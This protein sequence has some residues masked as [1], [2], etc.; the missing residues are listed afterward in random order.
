MSFPKQSKDQTPFEKAIYTFAQETE[1]PFSLNQLLSHLKHSLRYMPDQ[2]PAL[3]QRALEK[4]PSVFF[5][6]DQSHYVPRDY[7]FDGKSFLIK[8]TPLEIERGCLILGHRLLPFAPADGHLGQPSLRP[9]DRKRPLKTVEQ[10]F[11]MK[12][13]GIF[14][15]MCGIHKLI[16]DT[17]PLE[18]LSTKETLMADSDAGSDRVALTVFDLRAFFKRY[19]PSKDCGLKV[20]LHSYNEQTY[21]FEMVHQIG[22]KQDEFLIR[23]WTE[24][25]EKSITRLNSELGP[26]Y[27]VE[28]QLG[29]ALFRN[30]HLLERTPPIHIGGALALFKDLALQNLNNMPIFWSRQ[31]DVEHIFLDLADAQSPEPLG[32]LESIPDI[33]QDLGIQVSMELVNAYVLNG[34]Y[35]GQK[36]YEPIFDH[37]CEV[38]G[39]FEFYNAEQE[40]VFLQQLKEVF[41]NLAANYKREND[42]NL[43]MLRQRALGLFDHFWTI[44]R[45]EIP[46][47]TL[48]QADI[49]PLSTM[50]MLMGEL[51][52][53]MNLEHNDSEFD[54]NVLMF[55]DQNLSQLE[56]MF[57]TMVDDYIGATNNASDAAPPKPVAPTDQASGPPIPQPKP[58]AK[59]KTKPTQVSHFTVY[60]GEKG[61]S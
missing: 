39:K 23:R 30:P 51:T 12:E 52:G 4:D 36:S 55:L 48:E 13:L 50:G 53:L 6:S 10:E 8:L 16:A 19:P 1:A 41:D 25:F 54:P 22:S 38:H 20:T 44:S 43:G 15:S 60:E 3:V 24:E 35:E 21:S 31:S 32:A 18:D 27:P 42:Q 61:D 29:M 37:M 9:L 56:Q 5:D 2:L 11:A 57:Y 40:T 45:L 46:D 47:E 7:V 34:L 58:A 28:V 26:R 17:T 59:P 33:L 49:F 14:Y